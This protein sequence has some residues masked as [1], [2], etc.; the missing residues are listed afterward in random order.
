MSKYDVITLGNRTFVQEWYIIHHLNIMHPYPHKHGGRDGEW[1]SK[2]GVFT[3]SSKFL[4]YC[5]R[6]CLQPSLMQILLL[7]CFHDFLS[8]GERLNTLHHV[9]E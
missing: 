7:P 4:F 3:Q 1:T 8:K 5:D 9:L 2:F 6:S